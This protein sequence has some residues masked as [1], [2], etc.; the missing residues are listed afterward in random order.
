MANFLEDGS[1]WLEGQRHTHLASPI[2][3]RRGSDAVPL[4]ATIGRTVFRIDNAYGIP[5][6]IESR[7]F[8]I[9]AQDLVFGAV[10][11]L[12]QRGDQ[13]D[14]IRDD[15]TYTYEVMAPGKEPHWRWSDSFRQTIRVHTKQIK[16][17]TT[18]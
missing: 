14:E 16:T 3:Y 11:V 12:P 7:D 8:L 6:R 18:P 10:K 17:E 4:M 13:I 9:R 15:T 5:E 1:A 2:I